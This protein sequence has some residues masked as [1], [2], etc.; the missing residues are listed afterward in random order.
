MKASLTSF[1][2]GLALLVAGITS[3]AAANRPDPNDPDWP[4]VQ[5]KVPEL[6]LG[7]VWNG[8][9]I[10]PATSGWSDDKDVA[11]LVVYLMQRRVPL[12]EADA[13]IGAFAGAAGAARTDKLGKLFAGLF[14][15]MNTERKDVMTGIDRFARK[16]KDFAAKLK[17]MDANLNTLRN[18]PKTPFE[19]LQAKND[20]VQWNL[21]VFDE[22][23]KSL[24]YVCEVPV[25]IEQRLF[26]LGKTIVTAMK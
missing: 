11:S 15:K 14:Q 21:R 20:E 2:L 7:Q 16:Q 26:H 1:T 3:A 12:D 6:A 5:I 10:D 8:P 24:T 18:D 4:C 25:N 17:S 19:T 22:R 13:K 9:A 23:Q